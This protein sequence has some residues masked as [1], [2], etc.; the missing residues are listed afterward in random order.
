M[1]NG[2]AAFWSVILTAAI[3]QAQPSRDRPLLPNGIDT[4]CVAIRFALEEATGLA[5]TWL[6][7][8][9]NQ[10]VIQ[11]D[12][13]LIFWANQGVGLCMRSGASGTLRSATETYYRAEAPEA[14][15]MQAR[16]RNYETMRQH[17]AEVY[18]EH[19]RKNIDQAIKSQGQ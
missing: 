11:N 17:Q 9:D 16:M 4:P 8:H 12:K 7:G 14:L 3:A 1:R 18:R 13:Q 19:A 15:Q 5:A 2:L 6:L 10:H